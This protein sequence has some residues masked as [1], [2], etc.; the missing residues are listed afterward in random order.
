MS[1]SARLAELR[2]KKG[3]S[4]QEVANVV[5]VSKTHVWQ[6]E[7]GRSDNPSIELLKKLS[8]YFSVPVQ[9][10]MGIDD[11]SL[12]DVEA[13]QFLHDFKTL[14][15]QERQILIQTLRLFKQNRISEVDSA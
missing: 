6:M 8:D 5:G 2:M 1:M 3:K 9:F 7:K 11:I 10:L 14:S 15:E 4:L 12:D 13:Q